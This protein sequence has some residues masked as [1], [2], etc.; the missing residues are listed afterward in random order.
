MVEGFAA[1]IMQGEGQPSDLGVA[2]RLVAA[3]HH[4]VPVAGPGLPGW[5]RERAASELA[6]GVLT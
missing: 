1:M 2:H 4:A 5:C 6:V 3:G